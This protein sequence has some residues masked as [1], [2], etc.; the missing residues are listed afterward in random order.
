MEHK[1]QVSRTLLPLLVSLVLC[2]T[3]LGVGECFAWTGGIVGDGGV[4]LHTYGMSAW[5][6]QTSG[7]TNNLHDIAFADT[8]TAWAV[9]DGGVI[10]HTTNSGTTW[11]AQT[12]GTTNN[13]WGVFFVDSLS[14][15][16]V[17]DG[18][19]IRRTTNGG[20]TWSTQTS[21][22]SFRLYKVTF[23]SPNIGW[24]V[25]DQ[26]VILYT[27]NGGGL[28]ILQTSG[29]TSDLYGIS[30]INTT[31][32][33]VVGNGSTTLRTTDGGTNWVLRAQPPGA[34]NVWGVSA[35]NVNT[36]WIAGYGYGGGDWGGQIWNTTDGG[37]SWVF[38]RLVRGTSFRSIS[39][40]DSLRGWSVGN[41]GAILRTTTGDSVWTTQPSGTP[42]TLWA[43]TFTNIP[44]SSG[45][46][47]T[48]GVRD[49]G[50]G[51]RVT[52]RPNP[53]A[54]FA[55]IPGHEA[56]RFAVYDVS[57]RQ[58]GTY[59]GDR[60]GEGLSPGVYFVGAHGRAPLLRIVKVR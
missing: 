26:G 31:A 21:G 12:S 17:G 4:I 43:V 50:L 47:E 1:T 53:F 33:F 48:A 13:L 24:A 3:F 38:Q 42:N 40:I 51:I 60:I 23:Q 46:E 54:S 39:F 49:Q 59:K 29:T 55:A 20:T 28:W 8:N 56:E 27:P 44:P 37:G 10:R 35:L 9:G 11:T 45:V 2:L 36:A 52:A 15:W 25:G 7:T 18:G 34:Q 14:G 57:G 41:G 5:F 32:G 19:I 58:V 16:I 22:T 30:F 6:A